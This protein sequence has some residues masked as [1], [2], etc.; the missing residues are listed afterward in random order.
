VGNAPQNKVGAGPLDPELI[1]ELEAIAAESSCELLHAELKGGVLR[2]FL[3]REDGGVNLGDCEV[4]SKQV[5]ALLDVLDFGRGRYTLEVSSP[6]LDR[7]LYR[8]RDYERFTGH[9][10]RV[11][12]RTPEA[13]AKRTVV[14][15]LEAYRP[16]EGGEGGEIDVRERDARDAVSTI[17]LDRVMVA[18]L[19]VEL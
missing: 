15:R 9:L 14:G 17:P 8:P 16:D 10:V 4:V 1:A 13:D 2:L 3:D 18:R 5:S 19:E 7:Q 11:T 12:Y 6:G